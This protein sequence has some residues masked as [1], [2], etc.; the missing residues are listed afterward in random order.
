MKT[1]ISKFEKIAVQA[2]AWKFYGIITPTFF[3]IAFFSFHLMT[4]QSMNMM[5][6]GWSLFIIS[7]LVWWFWTIK[8]FQ[9]IIESQ[10]DIHDKVLDVA[11]EISEVKSNVQEISKSNTKKPR[12][13]K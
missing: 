10:I 13:S 7:C 11:K 6:L 5:I 4:D 2:K 8:I 12:Q 1:I 3:G 9:T